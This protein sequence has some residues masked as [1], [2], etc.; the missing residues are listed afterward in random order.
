MSSKP[1]HVVVH[2]VPIRSDIYR[3]V[4]VGMPG[5]LVLGFEDVRAKTENAK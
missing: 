2:L 1:D 3:I 4:S 5:E